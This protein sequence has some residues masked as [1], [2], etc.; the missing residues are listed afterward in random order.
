MIPSMAGSILLVVSAGPRA[1]ATSFV[2]S[3]TVACAHTIGFS[4]ECSQHEL[5]AGCVWGE[6]RVKGGAPSGRQCHRFAAPP[7]TISEDR[8]L[9]ATRVRSLS[10]SAAQAQDSVAPQNKYAGG[11]RGRN[12]RG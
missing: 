11:E 1:R 6:V 5:A 7:C 10:P 3:A 2:L 12:G 8:P 9:H 4:A